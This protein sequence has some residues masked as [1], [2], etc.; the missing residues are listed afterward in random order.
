MRWPAVLGLG[1]IDVMEGFNAIQSLCPDF[2][3]REAE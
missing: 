1:E 2:P 3:V